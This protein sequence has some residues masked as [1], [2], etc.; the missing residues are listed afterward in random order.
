MKALSGFRTV[1]H[2]GDG[3]FVGDEQGLRAIGLIDID[4]LQSL[5]QL[6]L[7]DL[8]TRRNIPQLG[9]CCAGNGRYATTQKEKSEDGD[10]E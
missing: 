3:S 8:L 9:E 6:I 4:L 10:E 7:R 1:T 2:L 5:C